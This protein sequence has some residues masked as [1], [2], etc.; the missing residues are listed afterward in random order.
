MMGTAIFASG[1]FGVGSNPY[2]T[3]LILPRFRRSESGSGKTYPSTAF[4][5]LCTSIV[6]KA[7]LEPLI[8]TL[9]DFESAIGSVYDY[10]SAAGWQSKWSEFSQWR[11]RWLDQWEA[12]VNALQGSVARLSPDEIEYLRKQ[13][14]AMR[15]RESLGVDV[16]DEQV[17]RQRAEKNPPP[18][19]RFDGS[20]L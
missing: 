18:L 12:K 14:A 4:D 17:L 13:T 6:K 19:D 11:K 5:R 7:A 20:S 15:L 2:A 1:G 16:D 8:Q 10:N 3:G 9:K